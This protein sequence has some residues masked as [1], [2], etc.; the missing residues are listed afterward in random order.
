MFHRNVLYRGVNMVTIETEP[1]ID[2]LKQSTILK[3]VREMASKIDANNKKLEEGYNALPDTAKMTADINTLKGSVEALDREDEQL[4][5]QINNNRSDINDH[6]TMINA[7]A[8]EIEGLTRELLS[9]LLLSKS[10][11]GIQLRFVKED[12]DYIDSNV[13]TTGTPT[14]ARLLPGTTDRTFK[15][16]IDLADGTSVV[17]NDFVIPEGGGTEVVVTGITIQSG[18]TENSF[19]VA[20]QLSDGTPITSNTWTID[21]PAFVLNIE[22][23]TSG[24]SINGT[25]LQTGDATKVGLMTPAVVTKVND[26]LPKSGGT[27]TGILYT[28]APTPFLIGNN[29][30]VGL[31]ATK[32]GVA[33]VCGQ[34]NISD[35]WYGNNQYGTQMNAYNGVTGKHNAFRISHEG[36]VYYDEADAPHPMA[37]KEEVTA[38][39]DDVDDITTALATAFSDIAITESATEVSVQLS[40]VDGMTTITETIPAATPTTAGVMTA[41]DKVKLNSVS[42]S[43]FDGDLSELIS[44]SYE[45]GNL[46]IEVLKEFDIQYIY[47]T[48]DANSY[49]IFTVVN[50]KPFKYSGKNIAEI[51]YAPNMDS[52]PSSGDAHSCYTVIGF[53][54]YG[55]IMTVYLKRGDTSSTATRLLSTDDIVAGRYRIWV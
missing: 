50:I 24:I 49:P 7:H 18:E 25:A 19:N 3:V 54:S 28:E 29:G 47:T 55:V 34:I 20:I 41:E 27:L 42:K 38:V 37:L 12:G 5:A 21:I 44:G 46:S 52:T 9:E 10:G 17:T 11:N 1:T 26:A 32:A 22:Q 13:L 53:Q 31:R 8:E 36:P 48:A 4:Q 30:K 40:K 51:G 14:T 2:A 45:N 6:T 23:T 35:S 16:S 15:L 33:T 39:A 43:V